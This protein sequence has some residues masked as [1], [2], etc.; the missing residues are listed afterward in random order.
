MAT[1]TTKTTSTTKTTRT[2]AAK[3]KT[4]TSTTTTTTT[5]V[6]PFEPATIDWT[7]CGR[8]ECGTLAVPLDHAEP[9]GPTIDL[10][11]QR[12]SAAIPSERIG[13]LF[14]NFGGPGGTSSSIFPGYA[15]LLAAGGFAD[16]FDLVTWDTRGTGGSAPLA[17][18]NDDLDAAA[19]AVGLV[20]PSERSAS[21]E[22]STCSVRPSAT[23]RSTTSATATAPRSGGCTPPS[24]PTRS[25][26]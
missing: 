17:C 5:T 23:R 19:D 25:A 22:T 6:A 4:T 16:R 1:R 9:D 3:P 20:D 26:P 12:L 8:V 21:L 13:S 15:G 2:S 18:T 14:L 10:A 7:P 11:V 24:S